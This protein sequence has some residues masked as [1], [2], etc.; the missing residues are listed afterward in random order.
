MPHHE[1]PPMA[2]TVPVKGAPSADEVSSQA[3]TIFSSKTSQ[4]SLDASYALTNL[5]LNSVGSAGLTSYGVVDEVKKAATNKKNGARR[6]GAMFLLGAVF[7]RFSAQEQISEVV[8]LYQYPELLYLAFDGLA[9]KGSSVR[10]GAQYAID[11]LYN[12]LKPESVSVALLPILVSYLGKKTGKWQGAVGAY[13]LLGKIAEKAKM[14]SGSREE[15]KIK[16]VLRESMGRR[17]EGI[18]PIVETGMHDL[19]SEV[20]ESKHEKTY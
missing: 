11:A 19:K 20:S 14:G 12:N 18:I 5:L 3:N 9:D 4:E 8:L 17:L 6:E 7:E 15:E 10:E 1:S 16:D 13:Q 2:T